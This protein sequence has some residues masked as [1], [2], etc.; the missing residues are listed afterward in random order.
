MDGVAECSITPEMQYSDIIVPTSDTV[1]GA[2]LLSMLATNR[3]QV[4]IQDVVNWKT[5]NIADV[6]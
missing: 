6:I 1:R 4:R 2:Y 5:V 3:K